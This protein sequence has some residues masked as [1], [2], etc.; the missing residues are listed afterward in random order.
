MI[1]EEHIVLIN[2]GK[3]LSVG[4]DVKVLIDYSLCAGKV[5][6]VN[7]KGVKVFVMDA[8][9]CIVYESNFKYEKVIKLGTKGVLV[10]E[11][12]KGRNG[13]GGYRFDTVMYPQLARNVEDIRGNTYLYETA[14]GVV[15]PREQQMYAD[16]FVRR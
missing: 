9:G 15:T 6:K 3:S 1:Y 12:W 2:K 14:F 4:D 10:W 16:K 11:T 8:L 7:P 13:R 5:S